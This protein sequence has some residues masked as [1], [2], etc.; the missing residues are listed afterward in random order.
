MAMPYMGDIV[1]AVKIGLAVLVDEVLP[2]APDNFKRL[3]IRNTVI[4]ADV[5]IPE[6]QDFFPAPS[7]FREEAVRDT[8][9]EV[10]IR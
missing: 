3:L 6:V 7:S 2:P 1:D 8:Q 4:F 5:I 10:G 9:Y